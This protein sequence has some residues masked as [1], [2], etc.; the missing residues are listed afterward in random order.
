VTPSDIEQY[1]LPT[2]KMNNADLKRLDEISR[3]IRYADAEWQK[4]ITD[5]RRLRVKAEQQA[6]SRYGMDFVVDTYL[7]DKLA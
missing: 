5:F 1:A 4:H 2:E 3:D 7:P 6:F